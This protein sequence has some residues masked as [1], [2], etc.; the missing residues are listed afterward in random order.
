MAKAKRKPTLTR[1]M[2]VAENAIRILSKRYEHLDKALAKA[3]DRLDSLRPQPAP[4]PREEWR[5]GERMDG[6]PGRM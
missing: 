5:S 3:L 1:R 4:P 2:T 6:M